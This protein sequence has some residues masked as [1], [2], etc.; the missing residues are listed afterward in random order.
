MEFNANLKKIK[1]SGIRKLFD[2]AQ[3]K[4]DLVSFGI[5]EPD[6]ITPT[7]I[8]EAAKKAI[9][10]GY[11]RYTPN[12]GFPE[13]RKALAI[14]LNQ[15][16]K[17]S[18]TPEEVVVTSGGTEALFFSFYT[19]LNPGDEVIIP[20]PGFVTYESQIY[21]AGGTP[22][23]FTLRG[24]NNFHPDL[25]ELK[26]C[27]T[28]KT[29]AI[30]LNSPSNPTGAAFSEDELSAI[31]QLA[32][33]KS[34]I[35]ISDELYEDIVYNGGEHFS[36]ASLPGMKER[37]ISIFGFSKSY[38]MTGWRLAYLAAEANLVKEMAKLLQNTAVCA[39]SVAQRAGLAA[40]QSS[41]D[42]VKE[43]FTAYNER[44]NVLI[45]GLNEIKGLSCHAPEG[46]FYAF[47]NIKETGMSAEEL[48]MYLLEE[49]KVVTVPGTAFGKQGEGYIRLS[50]ATSLEDIIEGIRRIKKGIENIK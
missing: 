13:F 46:T 43:M 40:I 14:K 16:N 12:L 4:K 32:Q 19:L 33:E 8:R 7:H 17:I 10:E 34:L 27:V 42:C 11:T 45:K 44:R 35:V 2:L 29:K 25:E 1:P 49:C 28:S 30:L 39:N 18:V 50:F 31:A 26:N 5:G 20:D 38:A 41:Q 6:F 22:V 23:N 48:S 24:E 9:D 3:G 15:K 21:F 47:V 36:I 37:T